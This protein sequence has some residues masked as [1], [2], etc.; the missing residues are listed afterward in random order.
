MQ[1]L[2]THNAMRHADLSLMHVWDHFINMGGI[3]DE[4]EVDAYLHGLMVLTAPERDGVAQSIN[5][6][7]D[8]LAMT[9]TVSCCRAPYSYAPRPLHLER[10]IA[11][12]CRAFGN[13]PEVR[14]PGVPTTGSMHRFEQPVPHPLDRGSRRRW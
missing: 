13:V 8:D 3:V 6:L 11:E 10:E 5:E 7:L 4:V 1:S 12:R 14:T 2:H 9:G